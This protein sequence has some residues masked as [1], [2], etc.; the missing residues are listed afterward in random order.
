MRFRA[1]HEIRLTG[2]KRRRQALTF[3]VM[4]DAS[5]VVWTAEEWAAQAT[6]H[7]WAYDGRWRGP[8]P[9]GYATV[10]VRRLATSRRAAR[11][12][13]TLRAGGEPT[14]SAMTVRMTRLELADITRAAKS[15]GKKRSVWARDVLV[16][17]AR[18]RVITA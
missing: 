4:V 10:R 6:E 2:Y 11:G 13:T 1:T 18:K 15:S 7:A 12:R 8:I 17:A 14:R 5:G 3:R 16:D 9:D